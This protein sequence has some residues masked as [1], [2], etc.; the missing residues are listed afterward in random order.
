MG[1]AEKIGIYKKENDI[2]ILQTNRWNE[3]LEQA[4]RQGST[5]GLTPAFVEQYLSAVHLESI[6]RQ[7][8]VLE[9]VAQNSGASDF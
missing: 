6:S 9:R 2:T 4:Q 8:K 7:N 5:V 1:V 3:V